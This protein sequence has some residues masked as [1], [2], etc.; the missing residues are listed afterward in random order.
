MKV[1]LRQIIAAIRKN[2]Y[3]KA[4]GVYYDYE[5]SYCA[6]GQA[7]R[8]LD[9][10][11]NVVGLTLRSHLTPLGIAFYNRVTHLND[12]TTMDMVEIAD[13]VELEFNSQ[14][15]EEFTIYEPRYL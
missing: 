4:R 2:G 15:D 11:F 10:P 12:K 7:A 13:M 5:G 14:L 1:N 3:P 6:L 8:N 9:L